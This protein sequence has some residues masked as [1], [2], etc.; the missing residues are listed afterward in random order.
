MRRKLIKCDE[1]RRFYRG[2]FS[3]T[4]FNRRCNGEVILLLNIKDDSGKKITEHLWFNMT[5][6]F[7]SLGL[8][9]GDE[10]E[11]LARRDYKLSYPTKMRKLDKQE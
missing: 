5:K 4:G 1:D 10:V 6:G 2:T 9:E 3:R 7:R 8:R 11:F